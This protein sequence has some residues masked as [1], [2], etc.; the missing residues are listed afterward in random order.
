[1]ASITIIGQ[2]FDSITVASKTNSLK[3]LVEPTVDSCTFA[4]VRKLTS[5]GAGVTIKKNNVAMIVGTTWTSA[6]IITFD[7]D[8]TV[9][10]Q[11]SKELFR[12]V[13]VGAC[14]DSNEAIVLGNIVTSVSLPKLYNGPSSTL[15]ASKNTKKSASILPYVLVAGLFGALS[16]IAVLVFRNKNK[17]DSTQN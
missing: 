13:A 4:G 14:G 3:Q 8:N 11:N 16:F 1:M 9:V 17:S 10:A 15:T 6:D 5:I 12:Y 2:T 7:I